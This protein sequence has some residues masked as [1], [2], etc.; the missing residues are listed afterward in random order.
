MGKGSQSISILPY[1]PEPF[2]HSG[3]LRSFEVFPET[4]GVPK[5]HP[6]PFGL[7]LPTS[8]HTTYSPFSRYSVYVFSCIPSNLLR[9]FSLAPPLLGQ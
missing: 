5:L 7:A 4:S 3:A 8:R 2:R 9:V 6:T 1:Y